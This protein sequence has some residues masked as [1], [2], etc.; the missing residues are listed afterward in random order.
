MISNMTSGRTVMNGG[1]YSN[2]IPSANSVCSSSLNEESSLKVEENN[3]KKQKSL[4]QFSSKKPDKLHNPSMSLHHMNTMESKKMSIPRLN[5]EKILK[6]VK[7]RDSRRSSQNSGAQKNCTS[8][9]SRM[10]KESKEDESSFIIKSP[11]ES[12]FFLN[13]QTRH[14]NRPALGTNLLN[15]AKQ[16]KSQIIRLGKVSTHLEEE[17]IF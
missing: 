13:Q 6:N 1:A 16:R 10:S 9:N 2:V 5:I 4:S 14:M 15:F 17:I 11:K 12:M 8:H 3:Y 7:N